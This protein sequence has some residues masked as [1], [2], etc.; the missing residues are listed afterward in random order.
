MKKVV[1]NF[2]NKD[3]MK[4]DSII[5]K[6]SFYLKDV[7]D[8][9]EKVAF[10]IVKFTDDDFDKLWQIQSSEDGDYIVALYNDEEEKKISNASLRNE[11]D[12]MISNA[13]EINI[14]YKGE[15]LTKLAA[16]ELGFNEKDLRLVKDYLP[17]KLSSN[18]NLVSKLLKDMS[19]PVRRSIQNRFPELV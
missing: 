19:E 15:V 3:L 6:K 8:K 13:N 11:W 9:I 2:D 7:K 4:L 17:K 10:D 1:Q 12:V 18:K 5:N 14:I 16:K